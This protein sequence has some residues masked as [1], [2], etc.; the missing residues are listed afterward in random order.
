MQQDQSRNTGKL[1]RTRGLN[2]CSASAVVAGVDAGWDG[3]ASTRDSGVAVFA[4]INRQ[5][6]V[7][8]PPTRNGR[9][10]FCPRVRG[11]TTVCMTIILV[12]CVHVFQERDT[13]FLSFKASVCLGLESSRHSATS[14]SRSVC[15]WFLGKQ[16]SYLVL[17]TCHSHGPFRKEIRKPKTV[18]VLP[19]CVLYVSANT[20]QLRMRATNSKRAK[21]AAVRSV[22]HELLRLV[23]ARQVP[24][25][26][27]LCWNFTPLSAATGNRYYV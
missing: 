14:L 22:D 23:Y 21:V 19:L 13:S 18:S 20:I 26:T 6:G 24:L 25:L 8:V 4:G 10:L 27:F 17:A 9:S 2:G 7:S 5:R 11:L 16:Q 15:D 3:F 1:L 12:C